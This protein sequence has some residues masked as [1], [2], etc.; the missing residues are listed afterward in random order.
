MLIKACFM[1]LLSMAL[2]F[3]A[4]T[5]ENAMLVQFME[6]VAAGAAIVCFMLV[7]KDAQDKK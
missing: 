5:V 4:T 2:F 1:A 3:F 7:T 6:I